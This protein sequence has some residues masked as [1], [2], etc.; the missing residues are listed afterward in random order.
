MR[1]DVT[2]KDIPGYRLLEHI[3]GT[4]GPH[5][6]RFPAHLREQNSDPVLDVDA[7]D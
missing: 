3:R 7:V 1:G 5:L 4:L 6:M 2:Q